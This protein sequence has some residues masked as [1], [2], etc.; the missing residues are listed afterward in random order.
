MMRGLT[1]RQPWA[2]CITLGDPKLL[3][4]AAKLIENRTWPPP[5]PLIGSY[6]AIHAGVHAFDQVDAIDAGRML[7]GHDAAHDRWQQW[8][9]ELTA[10]FGKIL[11]VARLVGVAGTLPAHQRRWQV[12][13]HLA[14]QLDDVRALPQPILFR[15]MQGLWQVPS[16]TEAL[17]R[18]QVG[19]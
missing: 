14:W 4:P 1:I 12:R 8:I 2:S 7:Y 6:I 3:G 19:L 11:S 9:A 18:A 16:E 15:G 10:G 17:I 13:R 5:Q